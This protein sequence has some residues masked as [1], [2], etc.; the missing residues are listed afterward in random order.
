[1]KVDFLDFGA[2]TSRFKDNQIDAGFV[3]AGFPIAS[4][5]DLS[6]TKDISLLSFDKAF[7]DKLSKAHPYFV[8]SKIP[9]NTYRGVTADTMTPAVMALTLSVDSTKPISRERAR[10]SRIR[11][12]SMGLTKPLRIR[13]RTEV[14]KYAEQKK[15][16]LI[17]NIH[18]FNC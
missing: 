4:V 11:A 16:Q 8:K 12:L 6:T 17:V 3:V 14:V 10:M 5:M 1:M 2:T 7:L 18:L 13:N 15:V 9:A